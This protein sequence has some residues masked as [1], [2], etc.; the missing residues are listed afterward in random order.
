MG[1]F[2]YLDASA[3][4]LPMPEGKRWQRI[5]REYFQT[6]DLECMRVKYRLSADGTLRK[7]RVR[8]DIDPDDIPDPDP[9]DIIGWDVVPYTGDLWFYDLIN[10]A[11]ASGKPRSEYWLE[12]RATFK[13]GYL[14]A[15]E[16]TSPPL[17]DTD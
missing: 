4:P 17:E 12:F 15:I 2:D 1:M 6:K 16:R 7:P 10:S 9:Q 8:P 11:L 3:Y 14:I 5:N 13:N